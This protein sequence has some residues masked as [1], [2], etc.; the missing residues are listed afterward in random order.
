MKKI[1]VYQLPI[2]HPAKFMR[3][4]FVEEK[5]I[6]PKIGDYSLVWEGEVADYTELDVIYRMLN[7]E[8]MPEGFKGHSLSVSDVVEVD[9]KFFYCDSIGW[10]DFSF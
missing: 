10:K 7:A 9:G 4:G 5:N 3:Y 1:K 2:E 8:R 6:I